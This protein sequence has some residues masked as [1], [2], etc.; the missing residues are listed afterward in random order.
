MVNSMKVHLFKVHG[1]TPAMKLESVLA[2][3][4]RMSLEDRVTYIGQH[5]MRLEVMAAPGAKGNKSPYWLLDLVKLRFENGPGKVSRKEALK[6]FDLGTDEGFG[7]LTSALYDPTTGYILIQ[8]N[9]H[10]PRAGAIAQYFTHISPS[11]QCAFEFL[12]KLDETT[13]ARLASKNIIKKLHYKVVPYQ[14]SKA[15]RGQNISLGQSL[16][17]SDSLGGQSLEVIISAG[18]GHLNTGSA[19]SLIG[20]FME[21]LTGSAIQEQGALETFKVYAKDAYDDV[22]DEINLIAAKMESNIDGLQL[23]P[24]HM[25][26][27]V[28]RWQGLQRARKGWDDAFEK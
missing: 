25:F 11:Q 6:G 2:E 12:V 17:M 7:E 15:M 8:Y 24:D 28:S 3:V 19:K 23:G 4:S 26:T 13:E 22:T 1:L 14:V 9:H 27:V 16:E 21:M 5:Q 18:K 20:T 10:G